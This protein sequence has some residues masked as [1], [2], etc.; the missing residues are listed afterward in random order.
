MVEIRHEGTCAAPLEVTFAYVDDY[1]NAPKWLWG[2]A[3]FEPIGENDHGLDSVFE[4]TY[5]VKPVKLSSTIRVTQWEQNEV[6]AFE[7]IK[8]FPTRSTWRFR[9][10]GDE[11]TAISVVFG[12][13][14]PGGLAGKALGRALEP[15]VGL[16]VRHSDA[17][18]RRQIE[19]QHAGRGGS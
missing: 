8:G 1:R 9:A 17:A 11:R 14:L 10:D 13:D 3:K 15:I 6:I 19:E 7:S 2:L 18:L 12:Y 5:H 16:S 4:G